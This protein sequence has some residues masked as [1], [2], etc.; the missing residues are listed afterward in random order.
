MRQ[1]VRPTFWVT[2]LML[3][4]SLNLFAL[5]LTLLFTA[6][7]ASAQTA[8]PA[9]PAKKELVARLIKLQQ[10]GIEALARSMVE[11]P[12]AQ[13]LD[14]AGVA[15]RTAVAADKQEAVAKEIQADTKKY[16]DE[17]VPLV[18]NR[19]MQL[20]PTTV[21]Q[22]MEQKFSEDEL[23]KIVALLESPE[24]AKYQQ[25]SGE[26]QQSLQVKLVADT[27]GSIETKLRALEQSIGK[28]LGLSAP[29]AATPPAAGK[30]AAK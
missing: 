6:H 5:S 16:L 7:T 27:R 4:N 19:A 24:Y 30:P 26:M 10:P 11:Q 8:A 13:M 17:A 21:G 20:A 2:C 1:A 12:A 22:V 25:L 14:G 23:R 15:L 3:K 9:S 18:R 29:A 28:R